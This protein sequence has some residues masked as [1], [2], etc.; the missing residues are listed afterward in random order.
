MAYR[1]PDP[2]P[3]VETVRE[4]PISANFAAAK[5]FLL[6]VFAVLVMLLVS[7]ACTPQ[8]RAA[9]IPALER[10]TCVLLRAV[11][12]SG[13]LDEVCATAD[14][15]APFLPEIIEARHGRPSLESPA[16]VVAFSMPAPKRPA[17]KRRCSSWIVLDAGA[18]AE[19]GP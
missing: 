7:E 6:G 17:P 10:A 11:T 15:L 5:G 12:N 16:P 2:L 8:D 3:V 9:A 4:W 19:A 14:E 13:T 18:D 1:A